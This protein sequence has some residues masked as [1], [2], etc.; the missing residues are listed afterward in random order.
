MS[1]QTERSAAAAAIKPRALTLELVKGCNLRCGYCYYADRDDAYDA[2]TAM[3][4]EVAERAVD[5]LLEDSDE[6]EPLHLHLFGGEPL[7][8]LERARHVVD[9]AERRAAETGRTMTFEV[10]TN[11]TRFNEESIAF[12]NEHSIRVGVS[13]DGPPDVQDVARPSAN[14]SS[15]QRA[16]PGIRR[17]LG[18][19][20]S[21]ACGR[22]SPS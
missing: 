1:A 18:R 21:L 6:A 9:Y 3:S 17:F 2:R 16:A 22:R 19:V 8:D 13:F 14:G 10:T 15:Y 5:R 11:G 20:G 4:P 12:L 7:L